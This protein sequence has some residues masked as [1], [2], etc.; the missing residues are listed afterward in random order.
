MIK[1]RDLIETK[2][3][4]DN[5]FKPSK[6]DWRD[7]DDMNMNDDEW[8]EFQT[9]LQHWMDDIR[10]RKLTNKMIDIDDMITDWLLMD[11]TTRDV[12]QDL[13]PKEIN[14]I[15]K[16]LQKKREQGNVC[17]LY[18]RVGIKYLGDKNKLKYGW[19]KDYYDKHFKLL[20]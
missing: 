17:N 1:L 15:S 13:S 5:P 7:D 18:K 2:E 14:R 12:L 10:K 20:R 3:I 4:P 19:E 8:E 11:E 6:Y 9:E 16:I